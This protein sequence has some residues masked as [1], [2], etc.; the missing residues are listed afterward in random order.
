M[1]WRAIGGTVI[2]LG[3]LFAGLPPAK[4]AIIIGA[5]LLLSRRVESQLLLSRRVESQR[6]YAEI[7]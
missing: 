6:V 1:G 3:L 4:A 2:L 7:D 5:L